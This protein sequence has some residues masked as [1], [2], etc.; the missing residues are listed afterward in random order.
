MNCLLCNFVR[1][2]DEE[3]FAHYV[4][5]H[6][7]NPKNYF[8]AC[9]FKADNGL[10]CK[11]CG[12]CGEFLTTK[13]ESKKH[14][15][16]KHYS[17]GEEK[18]TEEKPID[19]IRKGGIT[20]YQISFKEHSEE[21]DFFDPEKIVDEFLFNVKNLFEPSTEIYFKGDFAIENIQDAP[22][23]VPNTAD[24]K[25]L[26]YWS[27]NVYKAIYLNEYVLAGIRSDILKRVIN[28]KLSGSA[29]HF[30]RFF[31]LNLK[32]IRNSEKCKP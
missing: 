22:I 6:R 5:Y 18:P 32:T 24:I 23:G 4:S 3:V 19:V 8:F 12:R 29:W 2:T 31:Y 9:L 14:N 13:L 20:I 1:S 26:R 27:I 25:S 11:E 28:N 10:L 30:N 7:I 21:Y 16:L 17:V 15:F